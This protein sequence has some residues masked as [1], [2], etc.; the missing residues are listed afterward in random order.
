MYILVTNKKETLTEKNSYHVLIPLNIYFL[1]PMT[2]FYLFLNFKVVTIF[3]QILNSRVT[4][5]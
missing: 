2:N 1:V 3:L 4:D 5:N